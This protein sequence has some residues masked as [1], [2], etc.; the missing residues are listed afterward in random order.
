V[1]CAPELHKASRRLPDDGGLN[2]EGLAWS[3]A[4]QALLLGVRTP[5]FDSQAL[6]VRV[7]IRQV[8]GP[9]DLTNFEWLP[10]VRL[11]LPADGDE[12]GIRAMEF[13]PSRGVFLIITGNATSAGE[14]PFRLLAWDGNE[15]GRVRH[16][17]RVRFH[18][19]MKVEGV[20]HGWIGG[21]G[22]VVFVDDAGGYQVV[23]DDDPRLKTT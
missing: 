4:E 19:K 13:D 16:F 18:R 22:A 21:R 10:P 2:V 23:W 8:D 9:W 11:E 3:P 17:D 12:Q 20:T 14:A 15:D 7:R 1:E 5:V 6:V